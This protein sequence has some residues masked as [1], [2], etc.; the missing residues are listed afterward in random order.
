MDET[1]WR[2]SRRLD[3]QS[4]SAESLRVIHTHPHSRTTLSPSSTPSFPLLSH[5][6]VLFNFYCSYLKVFQSHL[7]LGQFF[8]FLFQLS[9]LNKRLS[10]KCLL[11]REMMLNAGSQK[12]RTGMEVKPHLNSSWTKSTPEVEQKLDKEGWGRAGFHAAGDWS[13]C[14]PG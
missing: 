3:G 13:W 2:N 4:H 1:L 8:I 12:N 9:V 14:G 7:S 5:L 6:V 10:K 11:T